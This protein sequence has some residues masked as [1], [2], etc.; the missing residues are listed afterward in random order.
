[1]Q[2]EHY[3]HDIVAEHNMYEVADRRN[4]GYANHRGHIMPFFVP[5]SGYK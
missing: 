2:K 5:V 1:M 3:M 4:L